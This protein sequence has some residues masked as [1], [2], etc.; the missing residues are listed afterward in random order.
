MAT[1][2]EAP[3]SAE[4]QIQRLKEQLLQAQKMCSVGALASTI[5]HEFNNILT[6]ILNYSKLGLRHKD[7][8]SRQRALEKILSASQRAA[9]LTSGILAFARKRGDRRERCDV[10]SLVEEVLPLVE[11]DLNKHRIRLTTDFRGR[12]Q[13]LV[14]GNQIQLI[15][16]NLMINAQQAMPGGGQLVV[17]VRENHASGMTEIMVRDFGSGMTPE[18]MRRI[19][20]PFFSTKSGPD[21]SG[22]GGTGLG[23]SMCRD[24]V[25]AHQG[26]I[27]VDS[28]PGKGTTFLLK[29]PSGRSTEDDR[30]AAFTGEN[31]ETHAT[32]G[33]S[34]KDGSPARGGEH[35]WTEG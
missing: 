33:A 22:K 2:P 30:A 23:L 24:I 26:R 35:E 28:A 27:R 15:L 14:N 12:P 16:I 7:E 34:G 25:E 18:T 3:L 21:Q 20:D 9:K 10:V 1:P 19:F 5:T 17:G 13:A 32:L 6:T 8:A 31:V 4:D 29:L 11:R